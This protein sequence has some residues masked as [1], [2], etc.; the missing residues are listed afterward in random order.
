MPPKAQRKKPISSFTL[1][2]VNY[3]TVLIR[4][5]HS[6]GTC[7]HG[8]YAYARVKKG[9]KWRELYLGKI[10][11]PTWGKIISIYRDATHALDLTGMSAA[12]V[13]NAHRAHTV[14]L[15]TAMQKTLRGIGGKKHV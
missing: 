5:G 14:A 10:D 3:R 1:F 2:G 6:C 15:E 12:E 9:R 13:G 7:P 8:P 11:S 4:C